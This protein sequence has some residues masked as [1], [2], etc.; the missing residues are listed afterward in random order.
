[1][2]DLLTATVQDPYAAVLLRTEFSATGSLTATVERSDDGG[3]TWTT[4]R[5]GNPLTLVGPAPGAGN[6]VG[7]LFDTEAPLN[8]PLRYRSTNNLGTV[9]LAGPVTITVASG[10]SWMKDPARPWADLQIS[11]CVKNPVDA[12]L[13]PQP[14]EPALFL[15]YGGLGDQTRAADATLFPILN[16]SRPADAYAYRKDPGTSWQIATVTLAAR[17]SVETFYAWGGPIF[18]QLDP[19]FGWPDRYY[20]PGDVGEQRMSGDL[21]QPFRLWPA[22]LTVVD[23][24]IGP[25]Q[26]TVQNNWCLVKDTFPTWASFTATGLTWDQVQQGLAAPVPVGGYGFGAYGDGPYGG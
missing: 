24:P 7:Y 9:T 26:G 4:V 11:Q 21:R 8:T 17:E 15:V 10:V 13:C 23:A 3:M 1:V 20:Q 18:L 5:G 22:P 12:V 2:A 19:L 6:R 16:R 25:A 14:E